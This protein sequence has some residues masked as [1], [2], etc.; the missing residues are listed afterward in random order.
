MVKGA[1]RAILPPTLDKRGTKRAAGEDKRAKILEAATTLFNRYGY[2]RTSIDL[3]AAEAQVAKP[4]VYAYFEDKE[5][6]FRAVVEHVAGEMQ[7]AAEEAIA[8]EGPIEE[9]LAGALAAKH[10]RYWELVHASPHAKELVESQDAV[11][12]AVVERADRAFVRLVVRA[13]EE[14]DEIDL[15]RAGLGAP[16]AAAL[17]VR[18]TAGAGYDATSAAGHRR[19]LGEIVRVIVRGMR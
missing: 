12:A 5:A 10:T 16:A 3:L 4:T 2:R 7:R 13:L 11:A 14:S 8:A 1:G 18:A 15:G 17:L 9:R 6:I 19:A